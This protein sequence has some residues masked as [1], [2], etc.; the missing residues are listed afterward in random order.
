MHQLDR[1]AGSATPPTTNQGRIAIGHDGVLIAVALELLRGKRGALG[2]ALSVR[3]E[4]LAAR[5]CRRGG[6]G[7]RRLAPIG[8]D[9]CVFV[10]HAART[11]AADAARCERKYRCAI[12]LLLVSVLAAGR[13][14]AG[15]G[16]SACG[17]AATAG[18]GQR[19]RRPRRRLRRP[20]P[21]P[22]RRQCRRRAHGV[23][24]RTIFTAFDYAY[25][26][27]AGAI[28]ALKAWLDGDDRTA[29]QANS[30]PRRARAATRRSRA[31]SN[32]APMITAT[33]WQ[34]V[35]DLP[36]WLSLSAEIEG[37]SRRRASQPLVRRAAVGQ[38]GEPAPRPRPTC[39]SRSR[40]SPKRSARRFCRAIDT[41]ARGKA[42]RAGEPQ[43]RRHVR[44]MHRSRCDSTVILGSSNRR[45][46]DR[47]GVLVAPYEAGPMPKA[48]TK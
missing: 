39:S 42:R 12:W 44:R 43:Q 47:I 1:L 20:Q 27:Q 38:G 16:R 13:V 46:F 48:T 28:P 18:R 29:A 11:L 19:S 10:G 4:G 36:G 9:Q 15:S 45:T 34:V 31:A 37:L 6:S 14:Q 24:K 25:P 2:R 5:P 3:Q 40:R 33:G 41:R 26:A 17:D 22:Q 30:S 35:T 32:T 7:W 8:L 23:K 21:R